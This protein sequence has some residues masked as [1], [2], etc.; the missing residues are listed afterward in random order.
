MTH[1]VSERRSPLVLYAPQE[2]IFKETDV[3]VLR[4]VSVADK[5]KNLDYRA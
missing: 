5:P 2:F 4:T 1:Y 3:R